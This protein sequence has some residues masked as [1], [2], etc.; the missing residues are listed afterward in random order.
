[1]T[2]TSAGKVLIIDDQPELVCGL[3]MLLEAEGFE[4]LHHPSPLG[5]AF[6][7]RSF[8]PDVILL[9]L[10]IPTLGGETVLRLDRKRFFPT[11]AAII[12][13]S[14]R[15]REELSA[16]AE[17]YAVDGFFS[18]GDDVNDL[19]LRMP[20]WV[21]VRRGRDAFQRGNREGSGI[22]AAGSV[23]VQPLLVM[24]TDSYRS[25]SA[26][27]L[28][29]GG[30]LVVKAASDELA[31]TLVASCAASALV[32]D[33]G[34]REMNRFIAHELER[35]GVPVLFLSSVPFAV[36]ASPVPVAVLS[37]SSMR[38]AL[39][40]TVDR[41]VTNGLKRMLNASHAARPRPLQRLE[42][43]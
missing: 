33:V 37:R 30:Y 15:S 5:L 2:A 13:C 34:T 28:Q 19:L 18:K 1:M 25:D 43:F 23:D 10:T 8:N 40:A 32:V 41:L 11:N 31:R 24:R 38:E 17:D 39:V 20:K 16:L 4:T 9:D 6:L 36:P 27:M 26:A 22:A 12:L 29:L 21:A 14:G 3:Q 7:L 42:A 35:T